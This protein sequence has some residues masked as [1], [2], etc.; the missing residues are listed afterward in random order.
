M[1]RA[2]RWG[3]VALVAVAATAS[4]TA[5]T[6]GG[7]EGGSGK[8]EITFMP[9][10]PKPEALIAAFEKEN[11][12]VTVKI[13][14]RG[15]AYADVLKTRVAGGQT[16]DV[17]QITAEGR[18]DILEN[19]LALDLSG[20]SFIDTVEPAFLS[21]YTRDNAVYGV[22]FTAWMGGIVY[23]KDLLSS[24][25]FD[26][27]PD[28]IDDTVKLGKALEDTGVLPYAEDQSFASAS[29]TALIA[30]SQAAAGHT[31][32][33]FAL[34]GKPADQTF[35][36]AWTPALEEW[37][38]LVSSG[39]LAPES[40]SLDGNQIKS[41]FLNGQAAT[42][43]SGNWDVADLDKAGIN[44]G[45]APFPASK[46]GT[47]YINGGGDPAFAISAKSSPEKQAAAK[48]LLAF[49]ASA[50][51]VKL[52]TEQTGAMSI[53]TEFTSTPEKEFVDAYENS[54]RPGNF[55]W[56]EF[57]KK[58]AVMV[59]TMSANQQLV[60]Q[61]Q[62]DAAGFSQAMDAESDK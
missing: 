37:E 9:Y 60:I 49:L 19:D 11:P 54:L 44:Y 17:F 36:E 56:L 55:F 5:C 48:K 3:A 18:N 25:G 7:S 39:F 16:P 41:A 1:N 47:S 15:D 26:S 38:Q 23:N 4:L 58:S 30:S 45:F 59:E 10:Q 32:A 31:A 2:T 61:G 51:G 34:D 43:R 6:G 27:F 29:L 46:G 13:S 35:S 12:D 33:E 50:D 20:E 22:T 42:Y 8:T 53:S 24:V 52:Q 40:L 28:N 57:S 14:P 21:L 62:Q